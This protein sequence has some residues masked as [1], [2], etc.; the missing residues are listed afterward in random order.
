MQRRLGVDVGA[1][2]AGSIFMGG[3]IKQG[4]V[5]SAAADFM[6]M[7]GETKE[8]ILSHMEQDANRVVQ[9]FYRPQYLVPGGIRLQKEQYKITHHL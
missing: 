7:G 2:V 4:L 9:T 8:R 3:D 1:I 6:S 5:L